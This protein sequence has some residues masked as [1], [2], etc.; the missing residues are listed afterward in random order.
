MN[1]NIFFPFSFILPPTT[2][3][4]EGEIHEIEPICFE[5]VSAWPP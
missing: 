5:V 2:R 4:V 3:D 1:L